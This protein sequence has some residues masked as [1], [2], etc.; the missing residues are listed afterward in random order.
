L[1]PVLLVTDVRTRATVIADGA[2]R[3]AA[4]R[5]GGDDAPVRCRI[6]YRLSGDR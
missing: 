5:A 1:S 4:A 6:A 3:V 2:R